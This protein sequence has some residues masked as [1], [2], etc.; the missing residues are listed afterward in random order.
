[1]SD[2]FEPIAVVG[3]AGRLPGA[4]D[5]RAYWRNLADGLESLTALTDEQ[6]LA[7]GVSR[8]RIDDAG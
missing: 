6:L 5:V 4:R 1:V 7:A 8:A 2:L 3:I